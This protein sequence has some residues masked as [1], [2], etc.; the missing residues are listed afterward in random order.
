MSIIVW[1]YKVLLMNN[2]VHN[3]QIFF[4]LWWRFLRNGG[5]AFLDTVHKFSDKFLSKFCKWAHRPINVIFWSN[6]DYIV[7]NMW[8]Y[9]ELWTGLLFSL[10][11][12]FC[13]KFVNL[14]ELHIEGVCIIP[15]RYE[16][17]KI[18]VFLN[19]LISK[20]ILWVKGLTCK[21]AF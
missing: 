11:K 10:G 3:L 1:V 5:L 15:V 12:T 17:I 13:Q 16:I 14:V 9:P 2:S 6:W 4:A 7:Q 19:I 18:Q 8:I 21:N 20:W